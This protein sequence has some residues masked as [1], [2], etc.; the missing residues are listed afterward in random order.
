MAEPGLP[1]LPVRELVLLVPLDVQVD[2]LW[3]EPLE[4][5]KEKTQNTLAVAGPH[6]T[7]GGEFVTMTRMTRQGEVF[8]SAWGEFTGSH[9]WRGYRW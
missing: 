3:I 7:D 8:P 6:T 1:M 4:T 2:N 5:H 9:V